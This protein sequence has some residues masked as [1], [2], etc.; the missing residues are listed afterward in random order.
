MW[1][2]APPQL[3]LLGS[4]WFW[5]MWPP[6]QELS[7]GLLGPWPCSGCALGALPAAVQAQLSP[8]RSCPPGG[9]LSSEPLAGW[10][11]RAVPTAARPA[12]TAWS[13]AP[14][15]AVGW[16][17]ETHLCGL[18]KRL[19]SWFSGSRGVCLVPQGPGPAEARPI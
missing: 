17:E 9:P 14:A 19:P 15:R 1:S 8:P 12:H 18:G 4:A 3:A 11:L 5:L 6:S 2:R 7:A 16:L 13:A 10:G